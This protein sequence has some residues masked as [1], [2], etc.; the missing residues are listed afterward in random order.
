MDEQTQLKDS[1]L[2]QAHEKGR[3]LLEEAK[4]TILKEETA[5]EERLIQD[6]LNQRSEQLKRIQR[7]LQRE[8]Q[9]IEN[10]KNITSDAS[11]SDAIG[12]MADKVKK[13]TNSSGAKIELQGKNSVGIYGKESEIENSGS[14]LIT[15]NTKNNEQAQ[16]PI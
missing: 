6:K 4:E 3:K 8:T 14:I 5:Q 2:A 1:I 15:K 9:Q 10:K 7:Q 11:A 12:I 16:A 13:V